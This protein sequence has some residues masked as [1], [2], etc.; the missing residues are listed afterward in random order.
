M[1]AGT[2][3]LA[4]RKIHRVCD[5][6]KHGT[7]AFVSPRE[8]C[9]SITDTNLLMLLTSRTEL[10]PR[11]WRV[12]ERRNGSKMASA[13]SIQWTSFGDEVTVCLA[14]WA[15]LITITLQCGDEPHEDKGRQRP[16][17]STESTSGL[18]VGG[19]STNK[20]LLFR[21]ENESRSPG[22][23]VFKLDRTHSRFH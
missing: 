8:Q 11:M 4:L 5:P 6:L 10:L 12:W 3:Y 19:D 21:H 1:A 9:N 7:D 22:P 16:V 2:S 13:C 23:A 18:Q 17:Y 20:T 15:K 14:P